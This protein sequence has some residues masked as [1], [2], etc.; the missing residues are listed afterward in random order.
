MMQLINTP[1]FIMRVIIV[2]MCWPVLAMAGDA[3]RTDYFVP[4]TISDE[5]QAI[6]KTFRR[7]PILL[8]AADDLQGWKEAW[9]DNENDVLDENQLAIDH[10]Q[11][12]VQQRKLAGI[13]VLDITPKGWKD[14]GKVLVYTHGGAYTLFSAASTLTSSGPIADA[15]G[16]RV[17][18]IDYTLA[19]F[20]RWEQVTDE[21]IA[22]IQAL[23]KEGYALE[24]MAIYGDS[25]GGGLAAGTVLKMRD[26]GIGMPAA[27][28]LLSPWSDI[29]E[30]GDT[31]VTLKEADPL[32]LYPG[33]LDHSADA[34]ADPKDQRNPYVSPVY[35]NYSKG[36]PPTL[37]QVGTKEIFLSNA[38]RHYQVLDQAGITVKLDAYEGMWHVFPAFHWQLP[39]SDLAR[40]KMTA[41]L[42]Q[43]LDY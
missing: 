10:Y 31:Y 7:E 40:E 32:L 42:K 4:S 30:S 3:E 28:V 14:N 35:G 22:V 38:V 9:Q 25:A 27:I 1:G 39:E 5:A 13:P 41:F 19:P 20:A 23:I 17:I 36:F 2:G 8:P 43:H 37:I 6:A 11:V 24:N 12:I 33:Q 26:Q 15:T 16:L 34:Y 21:V 18:S 29:T